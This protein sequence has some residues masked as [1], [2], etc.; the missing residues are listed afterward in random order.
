MLERRFHHDLIGVE[1]FGLNGFCRHDLVDLIIG[2][3]GM[4]VVM[5]SS[6]QSHNWMLP[7]EV[8]RLS[9]ENGSL[10]DKRFMRAPVTMYQFR[11]VHVNA[12]LH[13]LLLLERTGVLSLRCFRGLNPKLDLRRR[14][15]TVALMPWSTSSAFTF[16]ATGSDDWVRRH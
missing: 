7:V 10:S 6:W 13:E 14:R 4:F 8:D 16:L 11:L 3:S 5:C 2:E 9:R 15:A 12:S 1:S